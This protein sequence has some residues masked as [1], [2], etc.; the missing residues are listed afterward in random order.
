MKIAHTFF[1]GN[2]NMEVAISLVKKDDKR[3]AKTSTPSRISIGLTRS[4]PLALG[5]SMQEAASFTYCSVIVRSSR[6]LFVS[7]LMSG[8]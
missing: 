1:H 5:G 4:G 2:G 6:A 7:A 3:P 8:S